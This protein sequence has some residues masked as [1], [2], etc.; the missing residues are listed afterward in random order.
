MGGYLRPCAEDDEATLLVLPL[1]GPSLEMSKFEQNLAK[2]RA[3][4]LSIF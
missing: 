3:K 2:C 4:S 1:S